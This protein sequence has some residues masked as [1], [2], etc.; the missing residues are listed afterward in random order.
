MAKQQTPRS[1]QCYHC[2]HRFD[3]GAMTQSTVCPSC[4]KSLVVEDVVV[5][6]LKAVRKIQTCGRLVVQKKG[7][8]IAATVEALGGVHVEGVLDSAVVAEGPV[9]IGKT[10]KWKGDCRAPALSAEAGCVITRSRFQIGPEVNGG[11]PA[12]PGPDAEQ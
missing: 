6:T 8:V 9:H 7:H 5:G 1:V 2:R 3:V 12:R 10:A 11:E 4:H